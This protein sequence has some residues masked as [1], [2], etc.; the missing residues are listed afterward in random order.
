MGHKLCMGAVHSIERAMFPT[1]I[2][3]RPSIMERA[4]RA[5]HVFV[6]VGAA[7]MLV[8]AAHCCRVIACRR[9]CLPM[10]ATRPRCYLQ[11]AIGFFRENSLRTKWTSNES[12]VQ[13][14]ETLCC[15]ETRKGAPRIGTIAK[16]TSGAIK[17][18]STTE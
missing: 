13:S 8:V 12:N 17:I 3:K 2:I 18:K 11:T 4:A 15:D 9:R 16:R 7:A 14:F 10:R 5:Y 1:M 6:V